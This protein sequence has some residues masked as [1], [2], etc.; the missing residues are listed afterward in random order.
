MPID[1]KTGLP[2]PKT[3]E[4]EMNPGARKLTKR[5][6]ANKYRDHPSEKVRRINALRESAKES[7]ER[8]AALKKVE[9]TLQAEGKENELLAFRDERQRLQRTARAWRKGANEIELT[10]A[11]V[12]QHVPE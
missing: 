11:V 1:V 3:A 2:L 10:T 7:S 4:E 8:V 9:A 12:L 6:M 5:T